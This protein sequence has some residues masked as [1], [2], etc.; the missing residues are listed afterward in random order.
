MKASLFAGQ[1]AIAVFNFDVN[2]L[3]EMNDNHGH[4]AGDKLLKKAADSLRAV[5]ESGIMAFRVGGDEFILVGLH[6]DREAAEALKRRWEE[7]LERLNA[8]DDGV[9]CVI[10]CGMVCGESGYD[11]DELLV[12]ADERMYQD[13]VAKKNGAPPR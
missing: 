9:T 10:A 7:A 1:D 8:Q 3:K 12:K 5:E 11:L 2:N 6:L 13:K 4:E